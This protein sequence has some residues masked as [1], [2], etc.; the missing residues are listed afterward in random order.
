MGLQGF[1]PAKRTGFKRLII[2]AEGLEKSGKTTFGLSAPGPI[3]L[4]DLDI[5]TEGVV[6]KVLDAKKIIIASV[7]YRDAT[8]Q[9]EWLAM[10]EKAKKAWYDALKASIKEVRTLLGDTWTEMW[11]LARLARFGKLT[12]VMPHQYGP[13]NAEFRDM[14][15]R[16]YDTEKNVILIHKQKEEYI[17]DKNTGR[18][19]RSGFGDIGYLVQVNLE[20]W[21]RKGEFGLTVKDCR[22]EASLAGE[23]FVDPMNTFPFLA[24]QVYPGTSEEDWE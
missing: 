16:A 22:Q 20:V 19:K 14:I 1:E 18:M 3:A 8:N 7:N 6:D 23:E 4:F 24:S 15:K 9:T 2:S 13:V 11:E 21:R 12:Q 17:N 5:G 10:W